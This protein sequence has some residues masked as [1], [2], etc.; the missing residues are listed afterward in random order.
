[1]PVCRRPLLGRQTFAWLEAESLASE[2]LFVTHLCHPARPLGGPRT[3]WI[4]GREC[5][6]IIPGDGC[7]SGSVRRGS[8]R[9]RRRCSIARADLHLQ[10]VRRSIYLPRCCCTAAV[11]ALLL[12]YG[13]VTFP[14]MLLQASAGR[15]RRR[16]HRTIFLA[17]HPGVSLMLRVSV[18]CAS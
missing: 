4:L 3:N 12:G 16:R 1:M 8:A 6:G 11:M 9:A 17:F 15:R 2:N 5:N 14:E 18:S 7:I 13:L 10:S